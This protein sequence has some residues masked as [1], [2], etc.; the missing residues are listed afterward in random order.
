MD[1]RN[2][3]AAIPA[4]HAE[5]VQIGR[6]DGVLRV[7]FGHANQADVGEIGI[8]VAITRGELAQ[9]HEMIG[10]V[11]DRPDESGANQVEHQPGILEMERS[12]G[13]HRVTGEQ[14]FIDFLR[15][16]AGPDVMAI[17][18]IREGDN[19]T[20]VGNSLQDFEKPLRVER[21]GA[22]ATFPARRMKGFS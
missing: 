7:Q 3:L 15:N 13:Q 16:A 8:A 21:F 6:D 4:I 20:G 18:S 9:S 14:R 22:A 11:E 5:V 10:G 17:G 19:K 1:E 12:F 2:H